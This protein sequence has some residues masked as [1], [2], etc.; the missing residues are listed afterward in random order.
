[1]KSGVAVELSERVKRILSHDEKLIALKKLR[2]IQSDAVARYE[3]GLLIE[4]RISEIVGNE[5]MEA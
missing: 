3:V 4:K 5:T 1:M 2:D